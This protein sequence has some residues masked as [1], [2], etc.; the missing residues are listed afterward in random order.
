[1][2][3]SVETR[4]MQRARACEV[5]DRA[6]QQATVTDLL[7]SSRRPCAVR[8]RD[9]RWTWSPAERSPTRP[10]PQPGLVGRLHES[11]CGGVHAHRVL[12]DQ[13]ERM[14]GSPARTQK[15]FVEETL[16]R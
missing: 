13:R 16:D 10:V 14:L 3:R 8:Q 4:L 12:A 6:D 11:G 7:A 9:F 15:L 1:M 5:N 2:A